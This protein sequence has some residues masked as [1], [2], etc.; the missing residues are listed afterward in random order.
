MSVRYLKPIKWWHWI[1]GIFLVTGGVSISALSYLT[2][3]PEHSNCLAELQSRD[4]VSATIYCATATVDEQNPDKLSRAIKLVNDIPQDN[5][6]RTNGDKLIERWSQALMSLSEEAFHDGD[7][8]KAI[9]T[10]ELIP[11]NISLYKS[12]KVKIKEWQSTWSQAE[13]IYKNAEAKMEENESKDW[14]AALSTA[15]QLRTLENEYW[16]NTKYQE[17]VHN[18]QNIREEKEKAEQAEKDAANAASNPN[19][20]LGDKEA[21]TDDFAQLKKA[22]SLANSGKIDDMRA[23][24]IE[25]SV[26]IS[27]PHYKDAR[28]LMTDMENKIAFLE[29]S[30]YLENAKKIARKN[31][32]TSLQMAINE[33]GLI[34]KD[35]PLYK[36]AAAQIATWNKLRSQ[37][38]SQASKSKVEKNDLKKEIT[39]QDS[40]EKSD[41][42]ELVP[43][44]GKPKVTDTFSSPP[45]IQLDDMK[46]TYL[47]LEELENR[48]IQQEKR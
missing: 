32:E 11:A 37:I 31:D 12:V 25:A 47:R 41:K 19:Q 38:A 17:L 42:I 30:K 33:V 8:R 35:R 45:E 21:Q 43:V 26:I 16:A 9:E 39:N 46:E 20:D 24:V 40:P 23:A 7:L 1:I 5:P 2:K 15:K 6:L 4:S 34:A 48:E 44:L 18:I 27:E 22:R 14:Y 28:K 3:S 13:E 29:D 36:Q 10:A